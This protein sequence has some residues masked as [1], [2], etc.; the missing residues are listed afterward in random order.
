MR[1]PAQLSKE[2]LEEVKI[3]AKNVYDFLGCS[4]MTRV[5]F[6]VRKSDGCIMLNEPNTIPGFTSISMYPKMMEADGISYENLIDKLL[7]LAEEKWS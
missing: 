7:C 5:D 3:A 4:G 2:K 1:I 6:I